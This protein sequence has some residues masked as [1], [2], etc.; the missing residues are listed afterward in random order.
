[1][2][3]VA[4]NPKGHFAWLCRLNSQNPNEYFIFEENPEIY[5]LKTKKYEPP[6]SQIDFG[7][8]IIEAEIKIT[9]RNCSE[10][11][12]KVKGMPKVLLSFHNDDIQDLIQRIADGIIER[13]ADGWLKVRFTAKKPRGIF[14]WK[15]CDKP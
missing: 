8:C 2:K 12:F 7:H 6:A 1:M 10:W 4:P 3:P 13:T 5:N 11:V 14:G 9:A 15:F